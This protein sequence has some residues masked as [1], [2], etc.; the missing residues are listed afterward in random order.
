MNKNKTKQQQHAF[1]KK[2]KQKQQREPHQNQENSAQKIPKASFQDYF[3][4]QGYFSVHIYS[5]TGCETLESLTADDCKLLL[6]VEK[7]EKSL[8][9]SPESYKIW[10][11]KRW[12]L[13]PELRIQ[14][15]QN[16]AGSRTSQWVW[17][18]FI[19]WVDGD[20]ML[21][22]TGHRFTDKL[23]FKVAKAT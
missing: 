17:V 18:C 22:I 2:Q 23:R 6:V 19:I 14:R 7:M 12:E 11:I 8:I 3:S 9:S 5:Q 16:E 21:N 15:S 13:F 20:N 1:K 10:Y 4:R